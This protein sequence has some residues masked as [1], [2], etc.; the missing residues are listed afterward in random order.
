M[1]PP[2]DGSYQDIT[3][4]R[5]SNGDGHFASDYPL[6]LGTPLYAVQNGRILDMHDGVANNAPGTNPGSNAPSNWITLGITYR[7]RPATVYYQHMS[8]GHKVKLRDRVKEGQLLGY[9]GNSGNSSGP[10]LHIAAMWGRRT[11][12]DRYIY[13]ANDGFNDYVIF[14]PSNT[15][16]KDTDEDMPLND[17][18]KEFIRRAIKQEVP[19]AVWDTLIG[20]PGTRPVVKRKASW[21]M[22]A[23]YKATGAK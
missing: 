2:F 10:H 13:M 20:V 8:P 16:L 7:G 23:L 11:E 6:P 21:F 3:G 1:H 22:Q 15:W 18:D 17:A 5:Y 9:S 12:I 4:W 19:S 14:P